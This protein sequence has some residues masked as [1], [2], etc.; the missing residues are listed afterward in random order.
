MPLSYG[1]QTYQSFTPIQNLIEA[2]TIVVL[3]V[4]V[5]LLFLFQ[6]FFLQGLVIT[7]MEEG[8]SSGV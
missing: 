7:G 6:R 5:I 4:P 2:S 1:V 8:T 3:A